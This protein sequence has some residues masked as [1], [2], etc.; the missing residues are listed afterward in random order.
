MVSWEESHV[1]Q[2]TTD[3]PHYVVS[4]SGR[5]WAWLAILAFGAAG[6]TGFD[7][8]ATVFEPS[9]VG[10]IS[11]VDLLTAAET[12]LTLEDGRR[13]DIDLAGGA[14]ANDVPGTPQEGQLLI[15]VEEVGGKPWV[16][17]LSGGADCFMIQGRAIDEGDHL[18]FETGL[19]LPKA[20]DYD[21]GWPGPLEEYS[22]QAHFCINREGVVTHFA[23]SPG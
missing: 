23:G 17:A 16:L 4:R 3:R 11:A 5:V 22:D 10:V 14:T 1:R 13:I 18:V 19:R 7:R 21:P 9:E 12:A 8:P 6:C 15:Y 20:A 2:F